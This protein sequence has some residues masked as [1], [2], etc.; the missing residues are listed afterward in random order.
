[1]AKVLYQTTVIHSG[2]D[3]D[4][5]SSFAKNVEQLLRS[6]LNVDKEAQAKVEIKPASEKTMGDLMDDSNKKD[7]SGGFDDID[8]PDDMDEKDEL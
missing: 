1:M 7:F 5:T 3:L 2:Y 8:R 6:N 4:D